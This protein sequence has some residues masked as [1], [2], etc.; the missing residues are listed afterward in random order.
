MSAR[1]QFELVMQQWFR[2]GVGAIPAS[3]VLPMALS[4][5]Q[6]VQTEMIRRDVASLREHQHRS[7]EMLGEL[8]EYTRQFEESTSQ[9]LREQIDRL[10]ELRASTDAG[11]LSTAAQARADVLRERQDRLR[12]IER[13]DDAVGGLVADRDRAREAAARWLADAR[14]LQAVIAA[15]LPHE[16]YR[17]RALADIEARLATAAGN[18]DRDLPGS[19][20]PLA[21]DAYHQLSELRLDLELAHQEWLAGRW[22]AVRGVTVV[23]EL[24]AHSRLLPTDSLTPGGPAEL[25]EVDVDR[26]SA[27]RLHALETEADAILAAFEDS[28]PRLTVAE[29]QDVIAVQVPRLQEQVEQTIA[30]AWQRVQ[31]SQ[32]RANIA[33][34]V[35]EALE[36]GFAYHTQRAG[37]DDADMEG[38]FTAW[39]MQPISENEIVL[40]VRPV[41]DGVAA[42]QVEIESVAHTPESDQV[43]RERATAIA[44]YLRDQG[45]EVP[46]P[47]EVP[48]SE[49]VLIP[50]QALPTVPAREA[51]EQ[52]A[53]VRPVP[54]PEGSAL[55]DAEE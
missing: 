43:R 37:Y 54:R 19:A 2:G 44:Q 12:D 42:A 47:V 45:I 49:P 30:T 1:K 31:A 6:I 46:D 33:D 24:I 9:A 29:L 27:A 3:T 53:V 11:L 22:E 38:S 39:L 36:I 23:K 51:R 50:G 40:H 34:L 16:H 28:A 41:G 32:I 10:E 55:A 7:D 21:Q 14:T 26:A 18:L 15:T 48:S 35:A 17:P 8:S 25:T 20:L 13:L 5:V 4:A 52:G